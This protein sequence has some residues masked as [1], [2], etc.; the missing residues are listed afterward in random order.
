MGRPSKLSDKQKDEIRK[1]LLA[2]EKAID[3]AKEYKIDRAA[4]TRTF[5]QQIA[6]IKNV[7]NQIVAVDEAFSKMPVAQQIATIQE[8]DHMKAMSNHLLQGG[9]K[10]ASLFHRFSN[11]AAIHSDK[12]DESD[13]DS[14]ESNTIRKTI[15][16]CLSIANNAALIPMDIMKVSKDKNSNE[17]KVIEHID[18]PSAACPQS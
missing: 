17:K 11:L 10:A 12:L 8:A 1:R 3:L 6:T 15:A 4:I 18:R 5:S 7:A 9:S 14:E 16:Q 13:L 2:G